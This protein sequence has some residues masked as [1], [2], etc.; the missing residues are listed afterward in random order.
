M[1]AFFLN[2]REDNDILSKDF[3]APKKLGF[4]LVWKKRWN[5]AMNR[6]LLH[7]S[8]DRINNATPWDG[9]P[10]T[11][12]LQEFQVAWEKFLDNLDE[13]YKSEFEKEISNKLQPRSEFR[14]LNLRGL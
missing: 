3:L 14:R 2:V 1:A 8:Y 7:L 5:Q 6:Q 12:L 11:V 9:T 10:N 4:K 13:P